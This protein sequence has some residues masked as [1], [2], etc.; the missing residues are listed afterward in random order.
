MAIDWAF[1]LTMET[2]PNTID[3]YLNV[4]QKISAGK[5]VG[6]FKYNEWID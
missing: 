6:P 4:G 3:R 2:S 5:D 1:N